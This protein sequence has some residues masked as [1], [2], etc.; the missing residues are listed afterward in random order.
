MSV[1]KNRD[2]QPSIFT[3]PVVD[4][5]SDGAPS[6]SQ[7]VPATVDLTAAEE[8]EAA[9]GDEE[10]TAKDVVGAQVLQS[11]GVEGFPAESAYVCAR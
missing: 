5:A 8:P 1:P 6:G 3:I 7:D 10:M 11:S 9:G 4:A 2:Q